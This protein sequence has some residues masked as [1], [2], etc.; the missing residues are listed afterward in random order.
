ML[1]RSANAGDAA[2]YRRLLQGIAPALRAMIQSGLAR[3]GLDRGE[4]EDVLQETLLAIHLKRQTWR[5]EEPFLPWVRAIARNK[6]IDALRRRGRAASVP[7]DDFLETLA[8]PEPESAPTAAEADKVLGC[9]GGRSRQVVRAM[10]VDGLSTQEVAERL[11]MSEG[12]VRVALHRGL[13]VL[14]RVWKERET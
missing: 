11:A 2:A 5:E 12:A 6:L 3:H 13:S 14:A 9:L 4:A 8:A 10:A 7:I 1:M